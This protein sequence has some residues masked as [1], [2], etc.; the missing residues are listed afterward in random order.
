[1]RKTIHR[2]LVVEDN[3]HMRELAVRVIGGV[4]GSR[5]IAEA[6]MRRPNLKILLTSGFSEIISRG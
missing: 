1:V 6:R 4:A 2:I 3:A 5:F